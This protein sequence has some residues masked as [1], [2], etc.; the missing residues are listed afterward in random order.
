MKVGTEVTVVQLSAEQAAR[1]RDALAKGVYAAL[2]SWAVGAINTGTATTASANAFIGLLDV[3]GFEDFAHN[4]FE[5]LCIN[6]AN[7]VLHQFFLETTFVT[8]EQA[9]EAEGV[10]FPPIDFQD[11]SGCVALLEAMPS[12]VL[13][14]LDETCK[15]PKAS[16]AKFCEAVA[17][18]HRKNPF[19]MEPRAAGRRSLGVADAFVVRHFAGDV[20]Y[21]GVGFLEKN[22]DSLHADLA[23]A[24]RA[25]TNALIAGCFA[26]PAAP[27][28]G[29]AARGKAFRSVARAFTND[30]RSLT[31][32]LRAT[33]ALFIRCI[34]PNAALAPAV[35]TPA[36]VLAQLRAAG[37][38][39]AVQLMGSSYPSR[40]PYDAIYKRYSAQMPPRVRRLDPAHFVRRWRSRSTSTTRSCARPHQNLLPAVRP[41]GSRLDG[42]E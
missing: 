37:T 15:A 9:H 20:C 11:N 1:A 39:E 29:K 22:D 31:D 3:Y 13:R 42:N 40:I 4:S 7:E 30:L 17:S 36:L 38:A 14:L 24:L 19:Y 10:A 2:F 27:A 5:Q 8:E 28:G 33:S 32:D 41:R 21:L 25:A 26:E 34:K 16:D 35:F 23:K 12:G 6:F 18:T